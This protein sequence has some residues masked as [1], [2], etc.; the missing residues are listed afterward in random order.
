MNYLMMLNVS[1]GG[2]VQ[3]LAR[4]FGVD[5]PHLIS[6]IISFAIVC[7][8]LQRF[9]YKPILQM[10]EQRRRSIAEGIAEREAIKSELV[11][12]GHQ[13][14]EIILQANTEAEKLIREAHQAAE[15]VRERETQKA[16]ADAEQLIVKS[17][18]AA[19]RE[20]DRMLRELK[21]ELAFLV[22]EATE[23]ATRR[24]LTPEDQMR[25]AEETLSELRKAA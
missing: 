10:L 19:S 1:S 22:L 25:I 11:G 23:I 15:Y 6:Q 14:Q 13:R 20:H 5:W 7:F 2:Q 18:E 17:N 3:Q 8:L 9:A 24:V 4:T 21:Q 16:I 12:V